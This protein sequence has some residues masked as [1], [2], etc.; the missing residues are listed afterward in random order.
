MLYLIR[1]LGGNYIVTRK[2]ST[3]WFLFNWQFP[4]FVIYLI[5]RLTNV[6]PADLSFTRLRTIG[7]V[8]YSFLFYLFYVL[9]FWLKLHFFDRLLKW[10]VFS[11]FIIFILDIASHL[12]YTYRIER[13]NMMRLETILYLVQVV[14][15]TIALV[16]TIVM[17]V[18]MMKAY[19]YMRV[20][21][22]THGSN[23]NQ[24]T[25]EFKKVMKM[26]GGK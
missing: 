13:R 20:Y 16:C 15:L 18:R 3:R 8:F 22:N 1:C 23:K 17:Y 5:C 12:W 7:Q 14:S 4:P 9:T 25:R 19:N 6:K 24:I 2:G 21:C 11:I 26:L 10:A